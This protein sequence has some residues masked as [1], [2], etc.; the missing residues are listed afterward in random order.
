M[1][2]TGKEE[3]IKMSKVINVNKEIHKELKLT[4]VK[5]EISLKDLSTTLLEV[6]LL[7]NINLETAQELLSI[8]EGESC[9]PD[10]MLTL[11]IASHLVK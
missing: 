2:Y 8:S 7:L 6:G 10:E 3:N 4:S 5:L 1:Y 11:L 9:T